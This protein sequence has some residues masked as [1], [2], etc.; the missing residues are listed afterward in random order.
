[1]SVHLTRLLTGLPLATCHLPLATRPS[2]ADTARRGP[3]PRP[4]ASPRPSHPVPARSSSRPAA[5]AR[6]HAGCSIRCRWAGGSGW[7]E[8]CPRQRACCLLPDP[9]GD[10][11]GSLPG[12]EGGQALA[13]SGQLGEGGGDRSLVAVGDGAAA[14]GGPELDLDGEDLVVVGL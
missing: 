12:Q 14:A 8:L 7:C 3:P 4:A 5:A 6:R 2:D 13:G 10:V 1:S 11:A 9:P